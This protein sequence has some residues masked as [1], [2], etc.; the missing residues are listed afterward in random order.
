[1]QFLYMTSCFSP[2]HRNLSPEHSSV[3]KVIDS[4]FDLE[5]RH[6][7]RE[8]TLSQWYPN[9]PCMEYLLTFALKSP[10]HVGK[11]TIHG[12]YGV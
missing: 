10:S 11:Y 5:K 7:N 9:A 12:A 4:T 8:K 3:S 1:M 2:A 6:Q